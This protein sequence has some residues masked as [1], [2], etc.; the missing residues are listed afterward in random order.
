MHTTEFTIQEEFDLPKNHQKTIEDKINA[1]LAELRAQKAAEKARR[2]EQETKPALA[3]EP[4]PFLSHRTF[5]FAPTHSHMIEGEAWQ[6]ENG[7]NNWGKGTAIR[8]AE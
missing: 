3:P 1:R 2:A 4:K 8:C 6:S 5:N 7:F